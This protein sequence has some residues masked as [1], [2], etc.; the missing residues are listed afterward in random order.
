MLFKKKDKKEKEKMR[1]YVAFPELKKIKANEKYVYHSDYFMIDDYYATVLM[2]RHKLG[3]VDNFGKFWG[4]NL[5]PNQMPKGV[6]TINFD[7]ISRMGEG[8]I[9]SHQ[10]S[11][12]RISKKNDQAQRESGTMT[13]RYRAQQ[14]NRDLETI[15]IEL[16]NGASYLNVHDRIL[17]KAPDLATLDRAVAKIEREYT[18][19]FGSIKP[20]AYNGRQKTEFEHLLSSNSK[21][22]GHGFY[23]TSTE[24]AG[25]Y[26]LVTHGLEDANG[27]YVGY[28]T[29]DVNNSAVLF[30]VDNFRHHIA[31]ASDQFSDDTGSRQ[32]MTDMWGMKLAQ[33]AL[34][35]NHRVVHIV[36]NSETNLNKI[37]PPIASLTSTIDMAHGDV[38]MFEMFGKTQDE[39]IIYPQQMQ[40]LVLMTEQAYQPTPQDKSIIENTLRDT[41]TNFYVSQRMWVPD[42]QHHRD[43]LRIVGIPHDD[44]PKLELF[45]S[46]LDMNYKKALNSGVQD[47]EMV[48]AANVLKGVF[49]SLLSDNGDLFNTTTKSTIDNVVTG[50]RVIYDFGSLLRRGKGIAMAQL[51]NILGYAVSTLGEKDLVIVHGA[52]KIDPGIRKYVMQ[53]FDQVYDRGGRVAFLY[54]DVDAMIDN[55]DFNHYDKAD[56]VI[57]GNMVENTMRHYEEN[58][59]STVPN[60]LVKLITSRSEVINYIRRGTT[61]VVFIVQLPLIPT[62]IDYGIKKR[63][64]YN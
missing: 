45:V 26:N 32:H 7:Q 40:K 5:I 47:S 43:R 52:E 1:S 2:L 29:G 62:D 56:Y 37:A 44:V 35:N 8:W 6:V 18:D 53:Q 20:A 59:G 24:F 51:V 61:N 3:A 42:A 21:K 48:H 64:H 41:V 25:N 31:I 14:S 49:H 12:E 63:H 16:N 10:K 23:Y 36:L 27:E 39:L 28:M 46:Y 30:D 55:V 22:Y 58:L 11:S 60:D 13:T 15:A 38:N 50:K 54:N 19:R 9:A 57:T 34:L 33:S 4:V 17:V